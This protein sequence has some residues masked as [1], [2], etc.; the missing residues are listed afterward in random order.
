MNENIVISKSFCYWFVGGAM[1][2][3]TSELVPQ[4]RVNSIST[5]ATKPI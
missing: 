5:K 1:G 4:Q 2:G 3:E